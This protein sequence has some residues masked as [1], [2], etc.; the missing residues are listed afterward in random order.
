MTKKK[1]SESCLV[2]CQTTVSI[3]VDD[4]EFPVSPGPLLSADCIN[5]SLPRGDE[6]GA[7]LP[8]THLKETLLSICKKE[9]VSLK[10]EKLQAIKGAEQTGKQK[11]KLEGF[12]VCVCVCA[13]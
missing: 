6:G 4:D 8:P 13:N 12:C 1:K 11:V 2:A 3:A 10:M 5:A 7:S 9:L